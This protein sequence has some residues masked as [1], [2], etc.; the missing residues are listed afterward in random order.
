[1]RE[2]MADMMND[3]KSN[4]PGD[5]GENPMAKME[6]YVGPEYNYG[7]FIK[8]PEEMNMSTK[9]TM[10][11]LANNMIGITAY[12]DLLVSGNSKAKNSWSFRRAIFYKYWWK[13]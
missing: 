13:M 1:M 10:L 12:S 4:D 5:G 8:N 11:Q 3:I 6:E 9:G 2:N 7:K